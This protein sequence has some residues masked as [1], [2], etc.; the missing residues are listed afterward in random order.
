MTRIHSFD[1]II[2]SRFILNLR[3]AAEGNGTTS[4]DS[5]L[6]SQATDIHFVSTTSGILGDMGAP[7]DFYEDE[8]EEEE[9]EEEVE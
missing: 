6:P 7:V 5:L 3:V 2:M 1:G 4:M 8:E 9:H